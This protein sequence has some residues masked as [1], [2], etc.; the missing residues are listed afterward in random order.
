[1]SKYE[2]WTRSQLIARLSELD[3]PE[4]SEEPQSK[5]GFDVSS[6]PRRKIALK[7]CYHGWEYSGLEFQKG[8]T[9]MPTV[10]AVLEAALVATRLIDPEGGLDGAGFSKSGRTD[11]GVSAAGQVVSLWVRSMVAGDGENNAR[12]KEMEEVSLALE[13]EDALAEAGPSE[14]PRAEAFAETE[15]PPEDDPVSLFEST[16]HLLPTSSEIPYGRVLN[17][18]LPSSIR[19][20]SWSPVTSTFDARFSCVG[21]HYK[22]FFRLHA[23]LDL[24]RMREAAARLL[25]T[26]D[27][28]NFCKLDGSKGDIK[29]VRT[30]EE[31]SIDRVE[32][33][34]SGFPPGHTSEARLIDPTLYVLNVRGHGFLW[35]QIRHIAAVLFLVGQGLEEP[36][37]VSSLLN[38][39][40]ANSLPPFRAGE[41]PPE[42]VESKPVYDIADALPLVLWD[43]RYREGDLNW[44][45]DEPWQ[46][47]IF[48]TQLENAYTTSL[49]HTTL[50]SYFARAAELR[51]QSVDK[52]APPSLG[53]APVVLDMGGGTFLVN[54]RYKPLMK[55]ERG[56]T[57]DEVVRRWREG[58]GGRRAEKRAALTGMNGTDAETETV[59]ADE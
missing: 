5:P 51:P 50:L 59:Q 56:G 45:P 47:S 14:L 36:T 44:Q 48:R 57:P 42:V 8:H 17:R 19:I 20:L 21:R 29:Y 13:D 39:D 52:P 12:K 4:Q 31:V 58:A 15:P 3:V 23:G 43:S 11:R 53:K 40:P 25:G 26:H 32:E 24:A 41:Q 10:E 7:F 49:I 54:R 33:D 30:V 38:A 28:R 46:A 55:R 34:T 2:T 37:V 22:Y 9:H 18:V 16:Q 6:K 35:H 27:W 1:M